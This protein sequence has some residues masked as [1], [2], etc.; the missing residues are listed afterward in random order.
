[1][2]GTT[3]L[4]LVAAALLIAA[5]ALFV[6]VE[7]ALVAVDRIRIERLAAEGR[8]AARTALSLLKSLS[9]QRRPRLDR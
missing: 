1:M 4:G 2:D 3:V 6:A 7:F 5:N 9:F 8:R